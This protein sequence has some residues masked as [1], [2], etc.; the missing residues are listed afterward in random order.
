MDP[1]HS[2][3]ILLILLILCK[4]YFAESF[5]CNIMDSSMHT[6]QCSSSLGN[7]SHTSQQQCL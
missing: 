2:I 5:N 6:S 7:D 1:S 3:S 4:K